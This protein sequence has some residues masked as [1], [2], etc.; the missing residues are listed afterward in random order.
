MGGG[1]RSQC[2]HPH[3]MSVQRERCIACNTTAMLA[4]QSDTNIPSSVGVHSIALFL[5]VCSGR[6][7]SQC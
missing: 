2:T 1:A 6:Y 4:A 5:I 3:W 7:K